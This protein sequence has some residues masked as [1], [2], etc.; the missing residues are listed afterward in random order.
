MYDEDNKSRTAKEKV[1]LT[2]FHITS[3]IATV[4]KI[5]VVPNSNNLS[6]FLF[7]ELYKGCEI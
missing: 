6:L 2:H 7:S 5:D 1:R 3:K 4:P